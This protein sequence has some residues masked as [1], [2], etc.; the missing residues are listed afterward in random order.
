MITFIFFSDGPPLL[1]SSC[2]RALAPEEKAMDWT[3][4]VAQKKPDRYLPTAFMSIRGLCAA[5]V[6]K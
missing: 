2:I 1:R 4:H 5:V 3:Y 6:L